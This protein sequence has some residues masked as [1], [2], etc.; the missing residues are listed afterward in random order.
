MNGNPSTPSFQSALQVKPA[1][2]DVMETK[3]PVAERH[4]SDK[5]SSIIMTEAE[6]RNIEW[7]AASFP[8]IGEEAEP[9]EDRTTLEN[10]S[11]QADAE[12]SV[13]EEMADEAMEHTAASEGPC[14]L[15]E[16]T[17]AKACL[18]YTSPS[19]RD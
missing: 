7:S 16:E 2:F 9:Q 4:E 17:E 10:T 3:V 15:C 11:S 5:T 6:S 8:V 19:P 1:V 13:P 18:L 12:I 14:P